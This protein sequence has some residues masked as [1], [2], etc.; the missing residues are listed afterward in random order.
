[1]KTRGFV[2]L[3]LFHNLHVYKTLP[4]RKKHFLQCIGSIGSSNSRPNDSETM[5]LLIISETVS[6]LL[7]N[8][9]DPNYV[10]ITNHDG[11]TC[12][13]IAALTDNLELCKILVHRGADYKALMKGKV[14]IIEGVLHDLMFINLFCGYTI[15]FNL[16]STSC[17]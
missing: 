8:A 16:L 14:R 17:L 2:Y 10:N 11:R 9:D 12:L 5:I 1:M 13:H 3:F 4:H 7:D 15:S 6:F